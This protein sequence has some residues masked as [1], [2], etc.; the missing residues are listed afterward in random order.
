MFEYQIIGGNMFLEKIEFHEFIESIVEI[1]ET[2]DS[3]TRGHSIRVAH[4]S[5]LIAKELG[6]CQNDIELC[7][8]AGHLH[9]IGKIGISE[10]ILLKSTKLEENEYSEIKKHSEY[11]YNILNKVKSLQEMS[12]IVK[13]HHERWDG[14]GYPNGL[15]KEEIPLISRIIS[16]ADAFD[17]M[18][19]NRSYKIPM[20]VEDSLNELKNHSYTQFDGKIVDVFINKIAKNFNI[21]TY[22]EDIKNYK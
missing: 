17:A 15:S 20:G 8:F 4:Y 2:K 6:L 13:H 16:V 1:L 9:D 21:T 5:V 11:G 14:K 7:H 10:N 22:Q 3:Y 18:T 12:I 19:S